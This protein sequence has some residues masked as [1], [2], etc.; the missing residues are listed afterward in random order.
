MCEPCQRSL[1][2]CGRGIA[3]MALGNPNRSMS[4]RDLLATLPAAEKSEVRTNMEAFIKPAPTQRIG[5][6]HSAR[7]N[8]PFPWASS[9]FPG[10]SGDDFQLKLDVR[11]PCV[12]GRSSCFH[13]FCTW[14]AFPK[15]ARGATNVARPKTRR[16]STNMAREKRAT[17][18][19]MMDA[20]RSHASFWRSGWPPRCRDT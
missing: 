5:P 10:P 13:V 11:N 16:G 9:P 18:C 1:A 17:L 4:P 7:E 19:S 8:E 2:C 12:L 20:E 6:Y 14:R 15:H 3:H